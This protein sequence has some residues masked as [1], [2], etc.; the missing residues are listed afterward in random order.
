VPWLRNDDRKR[1]NLALAHGG[2]VGD[3][4]VDLLIELIST[5]PEHREVVLLL[6]TT[7]EP[8]ERRQLDGV[9]KA[10]KMAAKSG[11]RVRRIREAPR[12]TPMP[13]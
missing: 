12:T 6:R 1:T 3:A 5:D 10:A 7:L 2:R 13:P 8:G 4:P 9:M 11:M